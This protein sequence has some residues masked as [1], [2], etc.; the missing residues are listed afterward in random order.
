M[1]AYSGPD[2]DCAAAFRDVA[3]FLADDVMSRGPAAE[4]VFS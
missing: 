2:A 1:L 3:V 4:K